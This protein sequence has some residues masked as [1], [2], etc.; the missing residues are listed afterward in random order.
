MIRRESGGG[1]IAATTVGANVA[2]GLWGIAGLLR[3]CQRTAPVS[4]GKLL[5]LLI[6]MTDYVR[7]GVEDRLV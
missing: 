3:G 6:G 7:W 1:V 2:T 4:V 5:V